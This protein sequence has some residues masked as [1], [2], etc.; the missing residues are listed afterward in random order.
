MTSSSSSTAA[1]E[2]L[3]KLETTLEK[4]VSSSTDDS[5]NVDL[6]LLDTKQHT[7]TLYDELFHLVEESTV[8]SSR[9]N[10]K[11]LVLES[12][13]KEKEIILTELAACTETPV[14]DSIEYEQ[15]FMETTNQDE[16]DVK[17]MMDL[18]LKRVR[19]E[20]QVRSALK[21]E[22]DAVRSKKARFED[23]HKDMLM[24]CQ[25]AQKV[26]KTLVPHAVQPVSNYLKSYLGK[27]TPPPPPPSASISTT[28]ITT[29]S[30]Q[31]AA[32]KNTASTSLSLLDVNNN[33]ESHK[34]LSIAAFPLKSI[35]FRFKVGDVENQVKRFEIGEFGNM[36]RIFF[37][38]SPS[39]VGNNNGSSEEKSLTFRYNAIQSVVTMEEIAMFPNSDIGWIQ[40]FAG[41]ATS[42]DTSNNNSKRVS[43]KWVLERLASSLKQ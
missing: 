8:Q 18:K 42:T 9:V 4:L 40:D 5:D 39:T 15:T 2:T 43:V 31:P 28:T 17:S 32:I 13:L 27:A 14:T 25:A 6:L 3:T 37:L 1:T 24:K 10:E 34:L 11:S 38:F 12:L 26:F 19:E 16:E 30:Q 33:D 20:F 7:R 23:E 29:P 21:A 22:L 35:R 36:I 41:L